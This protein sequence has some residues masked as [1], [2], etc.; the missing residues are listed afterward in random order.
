MCGISGFVDFTNKSSQAILKRMT[1]TLQHRGPDGQGEYFETHVGCQLGLGHRRLSII[2]LSDAANQ[3][4]HYDGLHMVFNGEIYNYNEIREDLIKLGHEFKTHSDSEVILHAWRQWKEKAVDQ[5]QGMFAIVLFDEKSNELICIRDRAGVK[6]FYYYF[7]NGQFIF[8]SE[9]KALMQHPAFGKG[10]N[11]DAVASFLQYGY[12]SAPHCIFNDT[13]K[14]PAG[15][16]LSLDFKTQQIF[17]SQYWDV[18]DYYNKPKLKIELPEAIEETERILQESFQYRMVADVPVGV[19]LSGGYDSSCVTSLLQKNSTEKI[20]TFTIG[21]TDDKLNEAPFAKEIAARLGTDHTEYYCSHKEA[22]DIIPDLPYYYDEPFADSSAIPTILVSRLARKKVTVALSADAGDEVFAGYNR[23]DYI[24]RY[25]KKLQAIP[26][27]FRKLA[28]ATMGKVPSKRI[29]ILSKRPNFHSRYDKLKNLLN[30]PSTAELL[31]NLN[32]VFSEKDISRLM[33]APVQELDTLHTSNELKKEFYDPLSFM[34][35]IDYQT[36]MADDILQKVDRAAMSISLEGREPFLD[37]HII[38]WAAQLPSE[39]KYH[40][41]QKKYILKQ[42]VHKYLPKEMMERPKMGF[43]IPVESWLINELKELVMENLGKS[44]LR[45]HNLFKEEEV[46][47]IVG[48]FF[49][50]HREKYL[51][52]W[53]L[54]MFQLWYKKWF[55]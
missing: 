36:Y 35:A 27:P 22:L 9:L 10:I 1:E 55:S 2:D 39:F 47:K 34:M 48:D 11:T 45:L 52:V 51:K 49:N 14:L 16:L 32:L 40:K 23:Y 24:S 5:W 4:M 38:Q 8:G 53:Y 29:P 19:F 20:R 31:K 3:P 25:A 42:I 26:K 37:Q 7:K 44:A 54:L 21:T 12:V 15:H 6:P 17:L 33:A 46:E 50:G 28:A 18:Y 13:H 30:N 41:G 43:A